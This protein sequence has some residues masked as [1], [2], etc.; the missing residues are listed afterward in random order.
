MVCR[1]S[2][3]GENG[4]LNGYRSL[5]HRGFQ[6]IEADVVGCHAVEAVS[7][8][9]FTSEDRRRIGGVMNPAAIL[10]AIRRIINVVAGDARAAGIVAS[11]PTH[12]KLGIVVAAGNGFTTLVGAPASM[13]FSAS[14]VSI[15]SLKSRSALRR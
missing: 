14:G 6:F 12:E 1:N 10:A 5:G 9:G 15:G 7:M 13:V 8:T 4:S 2:R 3:R 11:R